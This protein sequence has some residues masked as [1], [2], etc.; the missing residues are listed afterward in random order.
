MS[1]TFPNLKEVATW[2]DSDLYVTTKR[3]I[4][5]KEYIKTT[6][7]NT[8]GVFQ[9]ATNAQGQPVLNQLPIKNAKSNIRGD[10][11]NLWDLVQPNKKGQALVFC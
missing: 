5:I 3:P 9:V 6:Q 8:Q 7:G 11:N 1:A 4:E 2:L 10:F